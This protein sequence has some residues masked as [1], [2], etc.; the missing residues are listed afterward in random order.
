[1]VKVRDECI[2]QEFWTDLLLLNN[3][4]RRKSREDKMNADRS[5]E[6]AV[7]NLLDKFTSEV[8]IH[9]L[10]VVQFWHSTF[11]IF[12][13]GRQLFSVIAS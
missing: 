2:L 1:M 4:G 13:Y 9:L 3:E 7:H 5:Q 11:Q 12:F 8:S 10:L 6:E